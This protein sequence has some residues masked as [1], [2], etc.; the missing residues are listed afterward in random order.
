VRELAEPEADAFDPLDQV[1]DG[2]GQSVRHERFVPREDLFAPTSRCAA[3]RPDLGWHRGVGHVD[4]QL[5]EVLGGDGGVVDVVETAQR[6][7]RVPGR[8]DLTAR[9]AGFEQPHQLRVAVFVESF[10]FLWSTSAALDTADRLCGHDAPRSRSARGDDTRRARVR[11][12]ADVE[13]IGDLHR[14]GQRV[15]EVLR[16]GPDR[17]NTP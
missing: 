10:V 4:D 14:V 1:V 11:E 15:V 3:Q 9:V 13:R 17:S 16:Y 2:F 12:L 7:F 5:V 6:L 8:A